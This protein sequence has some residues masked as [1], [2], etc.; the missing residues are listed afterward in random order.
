MTTGLLTP[1][2][3]SK[4]PVVSHAEP[5]GYISKSWGGGCKDKTKITYSKSLSYFCVR[6]FI[7]SV[8][9]APL[10]VTFLVNKKIEALRDSVI[11][12]FAQG[13]RASKRQNR[14]SKPH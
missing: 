9:L 3:C 6:R 4:V 5:S 7:D 1:T 2:V 13:L 12:L 14:E 10:N 8:S 11:Q